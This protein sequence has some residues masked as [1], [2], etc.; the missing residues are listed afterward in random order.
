MEG[1]LRLWASLIFPFHFLPLWPDSSPYFRY[2]DVCPGLFSCFRF[3]SPGQKMITKCPLLIPWVAH[4]IF[5]KK[6]CSVFL[7]QSWQEKRPWTSLWWIKSGDG[8]RL[9]EGQVMNAG[10]TWQVS[11]SCNSQWS[12]DDWGIDS[13]R[14][15]F[16]FVFF[17]GIWANCPEF[18][19]PY[20]FNRPICFYC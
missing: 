17:W 2:P 6:Y 7:H 13:V 10:F 4:P 8:L 20:L 3:L 16:W 11:R 1:S 19:S 9:I 12:T 18:I 15:A 5:T 14:I